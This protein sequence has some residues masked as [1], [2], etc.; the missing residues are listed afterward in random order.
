MTQRELNIDKL[1]IDGIWPIAGKAVKETIKEIKNGKFVGH[2]DLPSELIKV[3]MTIQFEL[4]TELFNEC[5]IEQGDIPDNW[6]LANIYSSH[7]KEG[8]GQY[9]IQESKY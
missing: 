6:S 8:A 5:R 4:P 7:K 2:E 1:N 9:K 3:R